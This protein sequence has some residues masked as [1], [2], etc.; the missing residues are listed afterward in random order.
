MKKLLFLLS[1]ISHC[2]TF[3]QGWET[4]FPF[5]QEGVSTMGL[6]VTSTLD[7]GFVIAG[8]FDYPTGAI[9]HGISLA[10][11]DSI[12]NIIWEHNYK[13]GEINDENVHYLEELSN[14]DF[15]IGGNRFSTPFAMRTNDI[16]EVIWETTFDADTARLITDGITSSDGNFFLVGT[17]NQPNQYRGLHLMKSTMDG[18]LLW[19]RYFQFDDNLFES[20]I[21]TTADGGAIVVGNIANELTIFKIDSNGFLEWQKE[22]DFLIGDNGY[23]IRQTPDGGYIVGGRISGV[24]GIF[25]LIFKTDS[26]GNG[27]WMKTLVTTNGSII[28][29]IIVRNDG[30]YTIVGDIVRFWFPAQNGFIVELDEN[31]ETIWSDHFNAENQKIA[32]IKSTLDGGYILVGQDP[33]GMLLK[34]ISGT[35]T[36]QAS[37]TSNPISLDIF[38]NP[39]TNHTTF[40]FNTAENK[41]LSI[42][43]FDPLGRMVHSVSDVN[44]SFIFYRKNLPSGLYFYVVNHKNTML[45]NGK[46]VID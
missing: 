1:I 9:R 19:K 43:I 42:Q 25:P 28:S 24:G 29:D 8:E 30:G 23:A 10:K 35:I 4:I 13:A 2:S 26:L 27:E 22:Y 44:R 34:K 40:Q 12:G 11:T 18:D 33:E 41:N 15:I 17:T 16:G 20:H 5:P 7:G 21:D 31:G 32:R 38:P 3:A 14:G 6:R 46:I 45:F 36:S 37:T 39:M